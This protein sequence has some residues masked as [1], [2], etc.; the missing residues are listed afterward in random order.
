MAE[1][2]AKSK[3]GR[4]FTL[5]QGASRG[6][7]GCLRS[8]KIL[9]GTILTVLKFWFLAILVACVCLWEM[10]FVSP[11]ELTTNKGTK[12]WFWRMNDALVHKHGHS[13]AAQQVTGIQP[14]PSTCFRKT[15]V[16]R[17]VTAVYF[18]RITS[19]LICFKRWKISVPSLQA[20]AIKS[21]SVPPP[22]RKQKH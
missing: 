22:S 13:R 4:N 12:G 2:G 3:R 10:G 19:F 7:L 14:P 1:L 6:D 20:L 18:M 9:G 16:S 11:L 15:P 21:L 8:R 17:T 5:S